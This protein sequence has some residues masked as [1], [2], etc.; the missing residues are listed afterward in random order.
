MFR[1]IK[2]ESF[3]DAYMIKEIIERWIYQWKNLNDPC[4]DHITIDHMYELI[5]LEY[6]R[7][8]FTRDEDDRYTGWRL[9]DIEIE[10]VSQHSKFPILDHSECVVLIKGDKHCFLI[11]YNFTWNGRIWQM[12][13]RKENL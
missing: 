9:D 12:Y 1:G 2:C 6:R 7:K 11:D 4:F 8:I 3:M 5:E 13:D 10:V